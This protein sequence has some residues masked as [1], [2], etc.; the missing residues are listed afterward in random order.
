MERRIA[1]TARQVGPQGQPT[2]PDVGPVNAL[3]YVPDEPVAPRA[4]PASAPPPVRRALPVTQTDTDDT[5]DDY[6]SDPV[7]QWPDA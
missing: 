2:T 1:H 3:K 7:F 5:T 6:A 4:R